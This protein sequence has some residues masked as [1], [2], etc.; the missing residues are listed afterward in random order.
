MATLPDVTLTGTA[1]QNVYAATAIVVGTAVTVQNKGSSP[2]LLQNIASQPSASSPNGHVLLAN[3]SIDVTGTIL[4]LWAKG[5]GPI[6][7]EVIT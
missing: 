7:V 5:V 4:G 2:I 3:E 1:Y 6:S